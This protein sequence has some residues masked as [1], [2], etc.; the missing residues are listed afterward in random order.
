MELRF[1]SKKMGMGDQSSK[2]ETPERGRIGKGSRRL[3]L[4]FAC[5]HAEQPPKKISKKRNFLLT[6]F[7]AYGTQEPKQQ[8]RIQ[9]EGEVIV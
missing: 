6:C 4:R 9:H 5:F 1:R 3:P 7:G 8:A 2:I